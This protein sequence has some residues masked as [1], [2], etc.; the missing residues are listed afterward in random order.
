MSQVMETNTRR[1]HIEAALANYP[2][3]GADGVDDLVR[4]FNKE[5]SSYDV[6]MIASNEAIAEAY[7]RFRA[8]HIDRFTAKDALKIAAFTAVMALIFIAIIWRAL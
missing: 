3:I 8:D 1:A 5:A 4:W 6:A 2:H 7:R